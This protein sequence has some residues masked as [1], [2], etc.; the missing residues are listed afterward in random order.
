MRRTISYKGEVLYTVERKSAIDN[1]SAD[2]PNGADYGLKKV[3]KQ[4]NKWKRKQWINPD[5]NE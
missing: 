3:D 1:N 4:T 2:N 5:K